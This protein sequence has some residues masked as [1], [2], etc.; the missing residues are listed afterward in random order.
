M[1]IL[2]DIGSAISAERQIII[3]HEED[4]KT[5][6]VSFPLSL[7]KRNSFSQDNE[8]FTAINEYWDYLPNR[9]QS[10]IFAIYEDIRE[11]FDS[12]TG[13]VELKAE[14]TDLVTKLMKYHTTT[15]V[16]KWI[17]TA[18]R[19]VVPTKGPR[20]IPM[21]YVYD[22]D[23]NTT[24]DKT[25][26]YDDYI[27]LMALSVIFRTMIPIW[28]IFNKP[29]KDRNGKVL[30]E[31]HAFLLLKDSEVYTSAAKDRLL[32]YITANLDKD[33]YTG[34][35]TLEFIPSSDMPMYHLS[36]VCVRKLYLGELYLEE[37]RQNLAA[38]VYTYIIERPSPNGGDHSQ[39]VRPK[40]IPKES[41]GDSG[42]N[43]GS[44]MELYKARAN[45]S[46]GRIAEMEYDFRDPIAVASSLLPRVDPAIVQKDCLRALETST[47]I[48]RHSGI[49]AC[50][51]LLSQWVINPVFPAQGQM[52]FEEDLQIR[53]AAITETVLRHRGFG[54]L[55]LIS[56]A[57]S[58]ADETAMRVSP[59]G[60]KSQI[61]E[62]LAIA[63]ATNYPYKR[64]PKRKTP[65][66]T[67]YDFVQED[68]KRLSLGISQHTW[69]ATADEALVREVLNTHVRRI[70]ILPQLRSDIGYMLVN[71]EEEF[72]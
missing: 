48:I 7:Y 67:S 57:I 69:R 66:N 43:S 21:D 9:D 23:K 1:R 33:S 56:T 41:A 8:T 46:V 71:A 32:R 15:A 59:V 31:K 13:I 40:K 36:L 6:R 45:I 42:E 68:I 55:A 49:Q 39:Q 62:E 27:G 51:V 25:Y 58:L 29:A 12:P 4:G 70:P 26:I 20:G 24:P 11:L 52:Y 2:A 34:N 72:N 50:Q 38:L 64:E 65:T 18:S 35:H 28:S 44:T 53:I 47:E 54:Y 37:P 10:E 61:S 14:L 30:K 5:R 63:L 17:R 16:E 3:E 22:V 19:L 60:S